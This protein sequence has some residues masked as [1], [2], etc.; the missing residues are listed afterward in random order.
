MRIANVEWGNQGATFPFADTAKLKEQHLWFSGLLRDASVHGATSI[1]RA[2]VDANRAYLYFDNGALATFT[3]GVVV[4]KIAVTRWGKFAGIMVP[5]EEFAS[6]T[7]AWPAGSFELSLPFAASV[8]LPELPGLRAVYV[9][10]SPFTG[11]VNL[12]GEH[13]IRVTGSG[14]NLRIDAVGDPAMRQRYC[15]VDYVES[16]ALRTINELGGDAG[17]NFHLTSS[18][19]QA[20]DSPVRFSRDG[21]RLEISL[22]GN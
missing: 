1:V 12:I 17:G 18:R 21:N 22:V 9:E 6:I 19:L 20:M 5:G 7:A 14:A 11:T 8:C 16:A 13:G 2:V 15:G 4:S 10:D 3:L